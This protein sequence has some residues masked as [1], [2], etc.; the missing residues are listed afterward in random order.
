MFHKVLSVKPQTDLTL[1]LTFMDGTQK[2]YDVKPLFSKWPMFIPL[3]H[4]NAL[5]Q[6]VKVD[7]GGYGISWNEELDLSC[8]E[9][10]YEGT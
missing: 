7:Q 2:K 9:L 6:S 3:Q 5:F 1:S 10:Y 8:D 4:D